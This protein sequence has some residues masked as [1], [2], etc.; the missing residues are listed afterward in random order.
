MVGEPAAVRCMKVVDISR[1]S[2]SLVKESTSTV[3]GVQ[4]IEVLEW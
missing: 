4:Q 3:E 2:H 1:Y